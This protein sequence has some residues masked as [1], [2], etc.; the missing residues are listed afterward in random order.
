MC[1]PTLGYGGSSSTR[2]ETIISSK[3]LNPK[4]T[5]N[6]KSTLACDQICK[7]PIVQLFEW[8]CTY[9]LGVVFFIFLFFIFVTYVDLGGSLTRGNETNLASGQIGK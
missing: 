3:N 5:K 4:P 8:T 7:Y 1:K 9:H 6:S 2:L